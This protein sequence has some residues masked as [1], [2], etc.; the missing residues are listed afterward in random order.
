MTPAQPDAPVLRA[1]V[2]L[3]FDYTCPFCYVERFRFAAL[4][5][6]QP[7]QLMPIPFE[8]HP[9]L[10]EE[11]VSLDDLGLRH[12]AHVEAYLARVACDGGFPMTIPDILPNTHR[13]MILAEVARDDG[14]ETHERVH[15][16]IFEAFFGRGEDIS[17]AEVLLRIARQA[18]IDPA[19]VEA[20]WAGD[21]HEE[22]QARLA[23]Y[24]RLAHGVGVSATPSALV[25]NELLIGSRPYGQLVESVQRC[26]ATHA[27]TAGDEEEEQSRT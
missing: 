18:G 27:Q 20:A 26:L 17:S 9:D 10:P 5:G 23:A 2:L 7:V 24:H 8:L 21:E 1:E 6:E 4:S 12:S 14:A 13:A 19:D 11:A 25:C 16:A 3:F 22:H 15:G